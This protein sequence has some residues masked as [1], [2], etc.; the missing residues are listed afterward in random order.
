[1]SFETTRINPS[2]LA[3]LVGS[4]LCHDLISPLGAIGNGVELLEM[5]GSF[6]GVEKSPELA[7]I[8]EAVGAA[9]DRIQAFRMAF[10]QAKNDQRVGQPE[11]ARLIDGLSS[12]GRLKLRLDAEG[13]FA[14]PE[15]RMLL[16]SVMCIEAA[17]PWG[18]Q[19]M[20]LRVGRGWRLIGE[21]QRMKPDEGLWSWLI[22]NGT[23][24]RRNPAPSEVQFALLAEAATQN[25]RRLACEIDDKG[26]EISF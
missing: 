11:L 15:V 5:S 8:A 21:A 10:G 16:L 19:V 13:D 18:G 2:E 17:M 12:Q 24:P 20:I 1:M 23:H 7:L 26:V 22:A 3:A 14:R 25:G 4:R 9:R 6:P